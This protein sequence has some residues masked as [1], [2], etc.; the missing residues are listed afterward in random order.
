MAPP[1]RQTS[2]RNGSFGAVAALVVTVPGRE[3]GM[4]GHL[5]LSYA[6]SIKDITEGLER[7]KW[8]LD[9]NSPNELYLGERKLI[10]DWM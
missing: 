4:E 8:A 10:R 2:Q 6:G 5:R 3:F 7:M 9:P 1:D